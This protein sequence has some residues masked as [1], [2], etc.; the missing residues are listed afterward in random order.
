MEKSL[1]EQEYLK[2]VREHISNIHSAYIKYGRTLSKKL[3]ISL[4]ELSGVV[5]QHDVSKFSD[6]EFDGYR[7]YFYPCSDE[8]KNEEL[9]NRAWEHHYSVN[10]HHPEFWVYAYNNEPEDMPNLYIAEM[11][12]DWEAM[13][14][15]F[16]GTTYEYYMKNR[17]KKPLSNNKR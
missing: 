12:L 5:Y 9:F 7:Q 16:G 17:D 6:E 13:S 10:K 8:T 14:M 2:Y 1:K 11:L 15:K 3:N 4:L